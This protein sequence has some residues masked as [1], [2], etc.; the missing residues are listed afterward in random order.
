MVTT[1]DITKYLFMFIIDFG[2][3]RQLNDT[4]F[5]QSRGQILLVPLLSI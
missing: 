2:P 5:F 3:A 4:L 1:I